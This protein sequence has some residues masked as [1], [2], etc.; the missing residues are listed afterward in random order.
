MQ[1][2]PLDRMLLTRETQADLMDMAGNAMTSTVVC[3]IML[4]GLIAVHEILDDGEES[5]TNTSDAEAKSLLVPSE[6]YSLVRSNL[7][8]AEGPLVDHAVLKAKAASSVLCC[9]CERQTG[10]Q[11]SI[12]SCTVCGHTACRSCRGNPTHSYLH[13]SPLS[14]QKPSEFIANLKG[15]VPMKLML[16][17]LSDLDFETFRSLCP[18]DDLPQ[19]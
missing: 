1:G 19:F 14:R 4:A 9:S 11:D 16:S 3:A 6:V 2:L 5:S 12:Y 8:V 18:I 13:V 10:V 7:Q 15:L 17:G